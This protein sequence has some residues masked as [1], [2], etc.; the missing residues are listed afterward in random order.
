MWWVMLAG[1]GALFALVL[2]LLIAAFLKPGAGA[3]TSPHLWL[4]GGGLV[5]PAFVLIPLLAYALW[6]GE[7]LLARPGDAVRVDVEARRWHWTFTYANAPGGSVVSTNV[8]HIPAG[9]TV[10]LRVTSADVIHSFWVPRLA[11]KIDAIPGHNTTLTLSA[12][13]PGVYR[14]VCAE[15][16]GTGHTTMEFIV[17]AHP[18]A[19]YAE[20][21][22]RLQSPPETAR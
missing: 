20:L 12:P 15:F 14:G 13:Q 6:G 16:C 4:T 17:E 10:E 11:G 21:L 1:S 18:R 22:A 9:A 2:A 3:A 19:D 8:M 7:R 5:L